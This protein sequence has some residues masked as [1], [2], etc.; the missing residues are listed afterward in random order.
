[1]FVKRVSSF[2]KFSTSPRSAH[3]AAERL[4]ETRDE[5]EKLQRIV[6]ESEGVE[7]QLRELTDRRA[8]KQETLAV[9]ADLVA[10]LERLA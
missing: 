2:A 6:G 9:A 8:R 4:N 10:N 7:R 3:I 1:M 5:K